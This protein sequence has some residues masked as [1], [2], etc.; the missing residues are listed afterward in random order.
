M[1]PGPA[2]HLTDPL[3]TALRERGWVVG[4][5]SAD[6]KELADR[7]ADFIDWILKGARPGELPIEQPTRY[8]LSVNLKA[9]R[10]VGVTIPPSLLLRA[11]QVIE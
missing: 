6:G 3:T 4:R 9:A 8:N 1:T 7:T 10:A 2:P 11:H 5:N